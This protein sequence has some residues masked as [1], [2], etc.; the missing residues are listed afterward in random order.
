MYD[1]AREPLN[2]ARFNQECSQLHVELLRA[3]GPLS[4]T[5]ALA[6]MARTAGDLMGRAADPQDALKHFC[7]YTLA[8]TN[9]CRRNQ[10]NGHYEKEEDMGAFGAE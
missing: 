10:E 4:P 6:V 9:R 1:W 7:E 5:H 8:A 3:L 2:E